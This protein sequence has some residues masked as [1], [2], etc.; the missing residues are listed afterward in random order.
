VDTDSWFFRGEWGKQASGEN[1]SLAVKWKKC[2]DYPADI[3]DEA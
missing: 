2:T 3:L 1:D